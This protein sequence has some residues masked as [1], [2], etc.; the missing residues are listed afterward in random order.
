VRTGSEAAGAEWQ[1][2][3]RPAAVAVV[4]W[5]AEDPRVLLIRRPSH[6][7]E[8]PGQL[9]CPG[10]AFDA[11]RD[12][13]LWETAQR[14]TWEEVGIVLPRPEGMLEPVH[15]PTSGY[16]VQPFL[17]RLSD[18]PRL[19]L[20]PAEVGVAAWVGIAEL[21]RALRYRVV[22]GGPRPVFPLGWGLLW[23]ATARIVER[24]LLVPSAVLARRLVR[25]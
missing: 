25:G 10:G 18:R 16:T 15:I 21:R 12:R 19:R 17:V 2:W 11:E 5:E 20:S 1:W 4:I 3:A 8:H 7:H 23:G 14:E 13:G 6:L 24:G 22:A 9:A